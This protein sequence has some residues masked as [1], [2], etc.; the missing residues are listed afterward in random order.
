MA[1]PIRPGNLPLPDIIDIWTCDSARLAMTGRTRLWSSGKGPELGET[2]AQLYRRRFLAV[3]GGA[4]A[5]SFQAFACR[6]SEQEAGGRSAGS[7][8]GVGYGPLEPTRDETTG[9]PLLHLPPGFRYLSFGWTGDQLED[10]TPTP[11]A[12][13]GMA[14]FDLSGSRVRLVRNHEIRAGSAFTSE[15]VYDGQAGGG[16]TT[17]EFDTADGSVKSAW[18][19]LA[20]TAMNCAGGPT[21]WGSWL[22]CEETVD[23]PGSEHGYTLPHGYVFEVPA[24]ATAKAE[25]Y[26]EMGRFVH[27]A[28]AIDS[29]SG[30]VY[31]TEDRP[32]AGFYRFL[33]N[34]P[35]QLA[36]GGR[37]E[38]MA[39]SDQG[40]AD[41]R[42][43]Q[44]AGLW[45]PVHWVPIEDPDP[46]PG[47]STSVYSQGHRQGAAT[48]GR[49]EGTWSGNGRI[50]VV[51]TNGGDARA[52]QVWEYD[53]GETR[54]RLLY[55]SP[56]ADILDMPDNI[57]VS[58]RGGLV[59]CED[60][61]NENFIRGLTPDGEIFPFAKNNVV[62]AG[63]RNG[64]EGDFRDRE[65]AGAT[66]SPDGEWLFFNAQQ[67]GTTFAV[68]GPWG[69]RGI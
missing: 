36:D 65:F 52:G 56:S 38:M 31:E 63:E 33:P 23:G 12:H 61:D 16:T 42:T 1:E 51:S 20:G 39:L 30:I 66:F 43:G 46:D 6:K 26:R 24:I 68:T 13:D 17:L 53:P 10:G 5:A 14:A 3:S 37:L 18:S 62:L 60:G 8:N 58:P 55:E 29:Q 34:R 45:N 22:S 64:L 32:A 27:E 67:P 35:G 44:Q 19:S 21:P 7:A 48:F 9:L 54:I 47:D 41:T 59:L 25:P 69:E 40:K 49:L 11:G 50:Y 28:V 4:F 15:P 57:C 2:A